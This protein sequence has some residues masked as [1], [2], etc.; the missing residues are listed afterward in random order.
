MDRLRMGQESDPPLFP[1][2]P[3]E[4]DR[5]R[6]ARKL[7]VGQGRQQVSGLER[8][9]FSARRLSCRP[10]LRRAPRRLHCTQCRLDALLR[11][12]RCL[13]RRRYDGRYMVY[14]RLLRAN[15]Q[16]RACLG[17]RGHRRRSGALASCPCDRRRR[18]LHRRALGSRRRRGRGTGQRDRHG[19]LFRTIDANRRSQ[20]RR[21]TCR[22]RAGGLGRRTGFAARTNTE[23]CRRQRCAKLG[24]CRDRQTGRCKDKIQNRHQRPATRRVA[25]SVRGKV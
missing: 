8:T 2:Q 23:I 9:R 19:R 21:G 22:A 17:W 18:L 12:H 14:D 11:Q 20:Q 16:A 4:A 5:R 3:D 24:L 7:V 6:T 13:C 25:T 10:Q 1:A 15:R